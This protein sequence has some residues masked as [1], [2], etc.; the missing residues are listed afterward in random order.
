MVKPLTYR[1]RPPQLLWWLLIPFLFPL[2]AAAHIRLPRLVSDSMILQRDKP[3][4]IWGWA[5]PGEKITIRFNGQQAHTITGNNGNW[6]LQLKPMKAGGPYRMYI[7]GE[8]EL[9]LKD[10]WLG[11][12][13]ICAGQ[14]NM[15]H[16]LQLHSETYAAVIAQARYPLI[17]QFKVPTSPQL[18]QQATDYISGS[19][20]PATPENVLQ[21]SAV[22]FFFAR[23][24]YEKY[25][26]PVGIINTS[27]G[28][29]PVEAWT[30]EAGLAAFSDITTTIQQNKDTAWFNSRNR[31]A[32]EAAAAS[33]AR[34]P[35]DQ[36]MRTTP[37]W[38]DTAYIPDG[39]HRIAV[40]GYWEDQGLKNLDGIVWF[41][42]EITVPAS[43]TH[44]PARLYL[45]RIV[46][47]DAVYVNGIPAGTT[48]YQYPQRRYT[49][50]AGLL[51][52]GTNII[53]VSIANNS[54]KGGFVPDKPYYLTAGNERID[55]S[56]YWQYKISAVFSSD[57]I[58]YP[59][60]LPQNQPAALYNGMAAPAVYYAVKGIAW[61]QG[62]SNTGNPDRYAPLLTAFIN[63]WRRQWKDTL[64][65][66]VYVQLPNF[67][68]ADYQPANSNWALLREAQSK[69][70]Q[71]PRT[72]MAVTIDLGEWNDIHPDNK[73]DVGIRLSLA[74]QKAAYNET[75]V[76]SGPAYEQT[77]I[78][79]DTILVSFTQTG[80]GL[81]TGNGEAPGS[82]AIA[83]ANKKFV[84]A[85]TVL[86]NGKVKVWNSKIPH[87]LYVRY[88]WADN[89]VNANL[90]NREGLP[91]APFRTDK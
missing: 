1:D 70:L 54:G 71:L 80:S 34:Q 22:A 27:A 66:V 82:F 91:A 24:L 46:D 44:M 53:T 72:A 69:A 64:L 36:G 32:M 23:S 90:Y 2:Q 49:L 75:V 61:Y 84:W 62:E 4:T 83:G 63:D 14:S 58:L 74:A 86:I 11:D 35:A 52:T 15:E 78:H 10:I 48:Y 38:Y 6:Q 89:P 68:E 9:Q 43:M 29:T 31:Q 13:W 16:S 73:K 88:A 18:Q 65:P 33:S 21:F 12:V 7:S 40:P 47:A 17:R 67:Q 39:W 8:N 19:W 57:T 3:L 81:I 87:P 45:G 28:G 56:G 25:Q 79:N 76:Y 50:P 41:R 77:E 26:I 85:Q 37:R 5:S 42:K 55:L 30:S 51:H 60:L 20:K 59:T